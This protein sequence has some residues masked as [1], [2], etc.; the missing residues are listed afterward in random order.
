VVAL[1]SAPG[2]EC[3]DARV[4]RTA[5]RL[6]ED[7]ASW[8]LHVARPLDDGIAWSSACDDDELQP[9][10]YAGTAG[11]AIAL[12]EAHRDLGDDR[13]ADAAIRGA[14]AVL[15]M[16]ARWEHP[17]L[18]FGTAGHGVAVHSI[19][20]ALGDERLARAGA[21]LLHDLHGRFDGDGWSEMLEL[22]GGNAGIALGALHV[23]DVE[24][25]RMAVALYVHT[26]EHTAHGVQWPHRRP[27]PASRLHH[28]SHGTLGIVSALASVASVTNDAELMELALAGASDV[29][30][31]NEAG[32]SGFLVPHSD[33]QYKPEVIERYSYGWCHGP[34]G[35]AQVFRLLA[36][37]TGDRAW[38][39]LVARCWRT[40]TT[41]GL[42]TRLRPGFWDNNGRC[43]GTAGVLALACD[44][45]AE[46]ETDLE[47]AS[48]LVDDLAAHATADDL[49]CRWSNVEHRVEPSL[50]EPRT[51]WAMGNAGILRELLRFD[52]ATQGAAMGYVVDWPDHANVTQSFAVMP[53]STT[54]SE[55]VE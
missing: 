37:V 17:S 41:S 29:V 30:A 24:L 8:L 15:S 10:L 42:P 23:G 26:A 22:I 33:P 50:L 45:H 55:P 25:A 35:D 40:V 21:E 18:Y 47:F 9:T 31:R 12:L 6:A 13:F 28:I 3:E 14:R 19:G 44:L 20:S 43:C 5:R 2:R 46:G 27:A 34:A 11:I 51:G 7:A 39:S 48:R 32:P 38:R 54:N 52:R 49:G 36:A 4:E 53:P 1:G 16:D